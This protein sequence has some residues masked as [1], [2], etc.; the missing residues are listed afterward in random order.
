MV[1]KETKF[2]RVLQQ[3]F[4]MNLLG[5]SRM[6]HDDSV[7]GNKKFRYRRHKYFMKK[8]GLHRIAENMSHND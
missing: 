6:F 2:P 1:T 4:E 7:T 8:S 5:L 3:K